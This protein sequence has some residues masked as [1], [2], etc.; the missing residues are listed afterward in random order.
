MTKTPK[1]RDKIL[2]GRTIRRITGCGKLYVT[3]NQ[4]EEGKVRELFAKLGKSGSCTACNMEAVT[5]MITLVFR[6]DGAVED[7]TK[8]LKGITCPN[9]ND[10]CKSCPDAIGQALEELFG[11]AKLTV[12]GKI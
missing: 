9:K 6:L 12:P 8:H 2:H 10:E 4:D 7:V 11:V 5:R 3:V 1:K